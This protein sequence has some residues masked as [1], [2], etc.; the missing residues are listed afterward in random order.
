MSP[1]CFGERYFS[2]CKQLSLL[3]SDIAAL[4]LETGAL[5]LE[6]FSQEKLNSSF[7]FGVWGEVN[8]GKSSFLNTLFR[9]N[10]CPT[11]FLPE[12]NRV[13]L[14]QYGAASRTKQIKPLLEE[15]FYPLDILR[16]FHIVDTPGSDSHISGHEDAS[17]DFLQSADLMFFV[18]SVA[19]PWCAA[20]WNLIS[21]LA[22]ARRQNA[23]FIIQQ[24]DLRESADIEVIFSHMAD[25]SQKR[26][27]RAMPTFAVSSKLADGA[28]HE[29]SADYVASGFPKVIEFINHHINQS[30]E[31]QLV[32]SEA[33]RTAESSLRSIEIRIEE[34][35]H[36]LNSQHY[37][38]ESLE[39]EISAMRERLV[40]KL[41]QHLKGVA[42]IFEK[43]SAWVSRSLH[44]RMGT[45]R[46]VYRVFVGDRTG[47]QTESLFIERL[48]RAVEE[49]AQSDGKDVVL[50]CRNH[51][52]E[53]DSRVFEA[54]GVGL[55]DG[56]D[57]DKKLHETMLR[58]VHRLDN[59]AH[60]ASGNL[61]VRKELERDLRF[62]NRALKSFIASTLIFVILGAGSGIMR[63]PWLPLV[64]CSIAGTLCLCGFFIA[65]ITRRRIASDFQNLLFNACT[66]FAAALREDYEEALR[67]FFQDYTS[68]LSSIHKHLA[69]EK[70]AVEPKLRRWHDL[71]LRL[72]SIEQNA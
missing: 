15:R 46:S 48:R 68:C 52:D 33:I 2:S 24:C 56:A 64:F 54:I 40:A 13:T 70:I 59:A 11:G 42:R 47:S 38:L 44:K 69:K 23:V 28:E 71:F 55:D 43:E 72:K 22:P 14:Y 27:G 53:L 51:W 5:A 63:L 41:P 57:I 29:L 31:R 37:F 35:S 1:A 19:N 49:I 32:F 8:A 58:F 16:D 3:T 7:Q 21:N 26:M 9:H 34:L 30:K 50:A 10:L 18:F 65:L 20:T 67:I 45:T 4:A 25:L 62:R 60:L 17:S 6:H 39:E 61:H 66:T 36:T 12:T